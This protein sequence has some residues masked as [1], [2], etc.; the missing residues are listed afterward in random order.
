[1]TQVS[2]VILDFDGV[3]VESNAVKNSAF[4]EFFTRYPDYCDA[5]RSFHLENHAKPR[6][7]KFTYYVEHLLKRPGDEKAIE[8]MAIDFSALVADRVI[9]C[10]MVSGAESF[11]QKFSKRV[12]LYI[13]SVTPQD[14]L[15]RIVAA[16]GLSSYLKRLYGDP[17]HAKSE[18]IKQILKS[19][20]VAPNQVVFVGDSASDYQVAKESGLIFIGR[21]SGQPFPDSD[22][23]LYAD[24]NEVANAIERLT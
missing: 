20:D 15:E 8:Q 18:A 23:D 9:N 21:D 2:V 16:R 17:P 19:E 22:F 24:L 6:C 1:V 10:P 13:S 7:F 12:P 4:D 14:E 3:I 11:L 5:M